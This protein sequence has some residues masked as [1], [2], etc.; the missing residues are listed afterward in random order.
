MYSLTELI[1]AGYS[2][3]RLQIN[4]AISPTTVNK[5]IKSIKK[6]D[7]TLFPLLG[8]TAE[9]CLAEGLEVETL[10]GAE[11]TMD[12]K[13]L[14]KIVV[15][16]EG[17]HR[18][19]AII[20]LNSHLKPREKPYACYFFFPIE[21]TASVTT[22]LLES[23]VASKP[24][25]GGDFLTSLLIN[26]S[27]SDIDLSKL[28]WNRKLNSECSETCS[29][30][31]SNL[32][33]TRVPSKSRIIAAEKDDAVFKSIADT[34]N[35]EYGKRLYETLKLKFYVSAEVSG[36]EILGIKVTPLIFIEE[37][38]SLISSGKSETEATDA[39]VGFIDSFSEADIN[40]IRG[41]KSDKKGL[42]REKKVENK[43]RAMYRDYT[44]NVTKA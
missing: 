20:S 19:D 39:L 23:N 36:K 27:D 2:I 29:W 7:G 41:Y 15:C 28:K 34:K 44:S 43:F 17:N 12:T 40:E 10:S 38:Q 5:K 18:L 26:R 30:L 21:S 37:F 13:G 1:E 3:A 14:D 8:V 35:F 32:E 6:C 24:W 42:K 31:W 22:M 16:L 9:A 33:N 25:A 4:R 11:V